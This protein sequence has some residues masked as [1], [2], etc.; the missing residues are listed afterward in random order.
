MPLIHAI[1][2]IPAIE[3]QELIAEY[4]VPDPHHP[5]VAHYHL[6]ESAI[7]VWALVAYYEAVGKISVALRVTTMCRTSISGP[8]S[9]SMPSKQTLLTPI[10]PRE[11]S[12]YQMVD[13]EAQPGLTDEETLR[14]RAEKRAALA[15]DR[16]AKRT[17][18]RGIVIVNTG[19]GKG[20][21]TA[22]LGVLFRAWGRGMR[23]VMFQ[24]IKASSGKWGEVQ[25]AQQIGVEIVPLGDGFTWE[26]DNIAKDRALAAAGWTQCAEKLRDPRT[27]S[28]FSTN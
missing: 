9:H 21:T 28:S 1:E 6:R 15:V 11:S 23:V 17:P 25:A 5:G 19:D 7:S 18:K 14:A 4:V 8:R 16:K 10:F 12:R 3:R 26:S 13:R 2:R 22:A 20:K 27:T 24:F